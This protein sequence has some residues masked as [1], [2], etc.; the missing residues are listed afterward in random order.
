MSVEKR[1]VYGD[2]LQS[3]ERRLRGGVEAAAKHLVENAKNAVLRA[4]QGGLAGA[5]RG[6]NLPRLR[7]GVLGGTPCLQKGVV[8]PWGDALIEVWRHFKL[9]GLTAGIATTICASASS[10]SPSSSCN[11]VSAA[12]TPPRADSP[13]KQ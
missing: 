5:T 9:A 4:G 12:P 6:P 8:G 3:S 11:A 10:L 13:S 7:F 2:D 1:R